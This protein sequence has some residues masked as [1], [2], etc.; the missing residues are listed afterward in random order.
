MAGGAMNGETEK[1]FHHAVH[2]G[3]IN[4]VRLMISADPATSTREYEFQ[5][6][7]LLDV[8]FEEEILDLLPANG[9]DINARNDEGVTLPHIIT[10]PHAIALPWARV[11]I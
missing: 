6:I 9:A 7:H 5:P 3:D 11:P 1:K 2:I 4:T 8:Y 10:D